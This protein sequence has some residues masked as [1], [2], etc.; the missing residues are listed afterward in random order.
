[1]TENEAEKRIL[2][3]LRQYCFTTKTSYEPL[4]N[5]LFQYGGLYKVNDILCQVETDDE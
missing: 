1:M 5:F 3:L 2:A 4:Y